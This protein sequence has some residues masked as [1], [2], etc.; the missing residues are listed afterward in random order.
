L[1]AKLDFL[2]IAYERYVPRLVFG[3]L[4]I[5]CFLAEHLFLVLSFFPSLLQIDYYEFFSD[6]T[7]LSLYSLALGWFIGISERSR[8]NYLFNRHRWYAAVTFFLTPPIYSAISNIDALKFDLTDLKSLLHC[9]LCLLV[10]S[11]GV[12]AT[13]AVIGWHIS[14]AWRRASPKAAFL[15]YVCT[16]VIML[17]WFASAAVIL[18]RSKSVNIHLHHLYIGWALALW[19]DVNAPISVIALAI[20]A[21]IFVQGIGAYSFAPVFTPQGCFD[22]AASKVVKCKF[23]GDS[24]FTLQV[25]GNGGAVAQHQCEYN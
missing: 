9:P 8:F 23:W 24:A 11:L 15:I 22:T 3:Y 6:I 1:L 21:G 14:I 20:G 7:T 19:C 2:K 18:A 10:L 13:T 5:A 4:L 17:V 16:R 25:C 12:S